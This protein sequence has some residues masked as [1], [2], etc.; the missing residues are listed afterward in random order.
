MMVCGWEETDL[1]HPGIPRETQPSKEF[2]IVMCIEACPSWVFPMHTNQG[3]GGEIQIG[4][5]NRKILILG[6]VRT[7]APR[8]CLVCRRM[9]P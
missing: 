8:V 9:D 1:C 5:G 7:G 2:L 4:L 3:S 6:R